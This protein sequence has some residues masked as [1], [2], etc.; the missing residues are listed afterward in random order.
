MLRIKTEGQASYV[1][2][3][4]LLFVYCACWYRYKAKFDLRPYF[5]IVHGYSAVRV[6]GVFVLSLIKTTC[7]SKV[8]RE[9]IGGCARSREFKKHM[10]HSFMRRTARYVNSEQWTRFELPPLLRGSSER[11]TIRRG[12]SIM[13]WGNCETSFTTRVVPLK[14]MKRFET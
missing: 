5:D 2:I 8:D 11:V 12:R 6:S 4:S 10:G 9:M 13:N 3:R 7:K 14:V 1:V